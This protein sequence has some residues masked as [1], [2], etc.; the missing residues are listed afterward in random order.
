[1]EG[2]VI[3]HSLQDPLLPSQ[4]SLHTWYRVVFKHSVL[5]IIM[6][7]LCFGKCD[8]IHCSLWAVQTIYSGLH[9]HW[10]RRNCV[11]GNLWFVFS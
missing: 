2:C 5:R 6:G 3:A 10:Q 1:M 9:F 4:S 7:N 8:A 11:M